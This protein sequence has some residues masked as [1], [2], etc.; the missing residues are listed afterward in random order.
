MKLCK[1]FRNSR[2]EKV[3]TMKYIFPLI[4]IALFSLASCSDFDGGKNADHSVVMLDEDDPKILYAKKCAKE[5]LPSFL[6]ALGQLGSDTSYFFSV[7][8]DFREGKHH[9]Y[10][11]VEIGSMQDSLLI[12]ILGNEPE[13]IKNVALGDSVS[14]HLLDVEDWMIHDYKNDT[15]LG[16]FTIRAIGGEA[17]LK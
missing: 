14:V 7:K 10:M 11:W 1:D 17:L 8:V 9:E 4:S 15:V 16:A 12:G 2:I 5:A 3:I 6:E 13:L